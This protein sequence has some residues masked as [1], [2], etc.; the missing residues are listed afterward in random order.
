MLRRLLAAFALLVALFVGLLY[1]AGRGGLGRH[2]GPGTPTA[3]RRSDATLAAESAAVRSARRDAR[4]AAPEAD[5]V[6]RPP[7]PHD[8]L[9]RRLH[10]EPARRGRRGRASARRRLRLRALLLGPRLLEHQR[11]RRGDLAGRT[12]ARPSSRSASATRWRATPRTRTP[13]PSS[14]GSGPRSARRPT[15][16]TATRTSCCATSQEVPA[17]PDRGG[18]H[19]ARRLH[20]E[21]ARARAR[22]AWRSSAASACATSS[23]ISE[24]EAR[25]PCPDGVPE[26]EL[27]ADCLE[28]AETP[29]D[30]FAKLDDWGFD[31]LVIPH[32]TTWG[33]YTPPGSKWDKQLAGAMHDPERQKLIEIYSGHGNSEEWR[34]YHA[35]RLRRG[36]AGRSARRRPPTYLPTCWRAGEMIR[37]R[38]L[39]AGPAPPTARSARRRRARTRPR[40]SARRTSRCPARSPQDWL[41]AGQCRDCTLPAFNYRPGGAAQ[42]ILALS[43][44]DAARLAAALPLRLHRL[45][46]QPLRAPRHRLQGGATGAASPSRTAIGRAP[47]ACSRRC[48][49][50]PEDEAPI[51]ESHP[52]DARREHADAASSSSRWSARRR[53]SRPAGSSPSTPTGATAA[54]S[55]T[56]SSAAR[57]TARAARA[58]CSGSTC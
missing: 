23:P 5:A 33:F 13:S 30:L 35:R 50:P 8:D 54:P 22:A 3:A 36:R 29:A 53:S 7:R 42:Y 47:G 49:A 28:T 27:P 14:A 19:A 15:T 37:E 31:S 9:R 25:E 20:A 52:F 48:S 10:P 57:S 41:D 39:A 4:R 16:T 18:R 43:N 55:G 58:S 44:F 11:P 12:G 34:D 26:R 51:A 17:R 2:Q 46:R 56:R 24:L 38:C 1:V 6:R 21:S 45:E 32:G 40:R